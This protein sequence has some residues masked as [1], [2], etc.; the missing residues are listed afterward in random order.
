MRRWPPLPPGA[1]GSSIRSTVRT[2]DPLNPISTR[3]SRAKLWTSSAAPTSSISD[4]A[5]SATTRT[6]RSPLAGA[7][8][9][10]AARR[11]QR[12]VQAART[13]L[14]RRRDA[15][16]QAGGRCDQ[17]GERDRTSVD[18]HL[19]ESRDVRRRESHEQ[20]ERPRADDNRERAAGDA[21]GAGSR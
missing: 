15:E 4:N 10:A 16:E 17:E 9:Q 12:V 3:C 14:E 13:H 18:A 7:G 5:I 11:E 20:P 21:P 6:W 1:R 19:V 8:H 2:D